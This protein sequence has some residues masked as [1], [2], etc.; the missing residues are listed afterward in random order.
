MNHDNLLAGRH[1]VPRGFCVDSHSELDVFKESQMEAD[2][3]QLTILIPAR[4]AFLF[5]CF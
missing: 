4:G 1:C 5:F 2:R 3:P